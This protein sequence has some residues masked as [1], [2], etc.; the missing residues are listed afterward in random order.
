MNVDLIFWL[1]REEKRIHEYT[2]ILV[3]KSFLKTLYKALNKVLGGFIKYKNIAS[4]IGWACNFQAINLHQ[5][6]D[7]R[8]YSYTR[9]KKF[10]ENSLQGIEQGSGGFH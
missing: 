9:I 10:L 6:L 5:R 4:N 8:V 7:K 1:V 2:R 3:L